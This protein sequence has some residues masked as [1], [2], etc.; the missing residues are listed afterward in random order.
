MLTKEEKLSLQNLPKVKA[1]LEETNQFLE[2]LTNSKGTISEERYKQLENKYNTQISEL[3]SRKDKI[4]NKFEERKDELKIQQGT[5]QNRRQETSNNLNEITQLKEQGAISEEDYKQQSKQYNNQLKAIDKESSQISKDFEEIDFYFHAKG[6]VNFQT[7]K[8]KDKISTGTSFF[9]KLPLS[10]IF[11]WKTI[12]LLVLIILIPITITINKNIS[13]KISNE[14]YSEDFNTDPNFELGGY[15]PQTNEYFKWDK[16][17]EIYKIRILEEDG[18][19]EKFAYTPEFQ[20]FENK[21]FCFEVDI[22]GIE[23]SWGM[24]LGMTFVY[25]H[26]DHSNNS[27]HIY[28]NG[29]KNKFTFSDEINSYDTGNNSINLN[30]WYHISVRYNSTK[31]TSDILVTESDSDNLIFEVRNVPFSP[32]QFNKIAFGHR[33]LFTDGDTFSLHYDNILIQYIDSNK[34]TNKNQEMKQSDSANKRIRKYKRSFFCF[35]D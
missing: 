31:K 15:S 4:T 6:D 19:I 27:M 26:Y 24:S 9:K 12:T 7:S 1:E 10:K 20:T 28:Y 22:K 3:E 21:S 8:V 16:E 32:S 29:T 23:K 13:E 2:Q 35:T 5:I 30:I 17:K 33:T 25:H 34:Y 11:N 18:G 14:K